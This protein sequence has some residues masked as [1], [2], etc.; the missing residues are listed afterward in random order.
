MPSSGRRPPL[1]TSAAGVGRDQVFVL[2]VTLD[3]V[4]DERAQGNDFETFLLRLLQRESSEA[5]AETTPF[6]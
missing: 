2:G 6:A 5:A 3:V 1:E 4:R